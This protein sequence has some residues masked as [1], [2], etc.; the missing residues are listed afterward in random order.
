MSGLLYKA[1]TPC[2]PRSKTSRFDRSSNES[3]GFD[4]FWDDH[5]DSFED[6]ENIDFTTEIRAPV[7]T[8]VKPRR[9]NRTTTSFQI[10]DENEG[11][12]SSPG[13]K[14]KR[15]KVTTTA[16]SN[17]KSALLS[18]PAQ[19]FRPRANFAPNPQSKLVRQPM[20]PKNNGGSDS[21]IERNKVL[22]EQINGKSQGSRKT[23]ALKKDVRRNTVYI[24]DDTTVATAFMGL[25]S[26]LKSHALGGAEDCT[27]EDTQINSL[28]SRIATKRQ[29]RRPYRHSPKPAPLQPS[30]KPAQ[31]TSIRVDIA[32]KNGGKENIPPHGSFRKDGEPEKSLPAVNLPQ[33]PKRAPDN[34][35]GT[36]RPTKPQYKT[37]RTF[38]NRG[39]RASAAKRVGPSQKRA[40]LGDKQPNARPPTIGT[41][42]K[43][44]ASSKQKLTAEK[45]SV[46]SRNPKSLG[47][48]RCSGTLTSSNPVMPDLKLKR[49]NTEYPLLIE[50]ISNPAMYNDNWLLHQEIVITQ[51]VNGLFD[52]TD[53]NPT[54]DDPE[55]LRYELLKLYQNE[56]F[57]QFHKR[58]QASLEYGPMS[59]PNFVL[60]RGSSLKKDLGL[61]RKLIDIL[62]RTYDLHTL[63]AAIEIV[64]GRRIPDDPKP[65]KK[66]IGAAQNE[67]GAAK[68]KMLRQKLENFIEVFL[69]RNEDMD[70]S[71]RGHKS[72][73]ADAEARAYRRTVLRSIMIITLLD[74]A[75]LRPGMMLPRQLF[76][77]SSIFK[78]SAAVVQALGRLLLPS[79]GDI[80]KPLGHLDCRLS[81]KQHE[82]QEYEYQI[83][84]LAV[85]L[86]DGVRLTR[87]VELL[88]YP[89]TLCP[90]S[91]ECNLD[92]S[93]TVV[94]PNG[95]SAPLSGY[96][97]NFPL[98][99][100][101]RFPCV[102]RAVK[103]FN[104]RIALGALGATT[105]T[106]ALVSDVLAEDIVDGHR[107][108]TIALLWGLVSKWGLGGLVDWDDVT[109]EIGRL[110][111][112][113]ISHYG[114]E[115]VKDQGW[116]NGECVG[117]LLGEHAPLLKQWTAL[118]AGMKGLQ[119]ENL[120][121]NFADGKIY[122]SIVD[123]YEGYI[124][125][126]KGCTV[127]SSGEKAD[128]QE[129]LK[130]R[131]QALGCSSQFC[132]CHSIASRRTPLIQIACLVSP[133]TYE[134]CHLL[135]SDFTLISLAFLC[136]RLLSAS[137]RARAAVTLQRAWRRIL[138]LREL[139]KRIIARDIARQCAAVV[140]ARDQII[141]AQD[142][143]ATWW[144]K[145][146]IRRQ[147]RQQRERRTVDDSIKGG[148]QWGRMIDLG[149][150]H[151]SA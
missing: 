143:I 97:G 84:N 32:G 18:Q 71:V 150:R 54:S 22:L 136:S 37:D 51:L 123:E 116:F 42:R 102:S 92:C 11:K 76:S 9:G 109:K 23:D 142:T 89:S 94:L 27:S 4:S 13:V 103:L 30:L 138:T 141:W 96:D 106:C 78:S 41:D 151:D 35:L 58:L 137:K 100:H 114:Y 55:A 79:S 115:E 67:L 132:M 43:E 65:S 60:A 113:A 139:P 40:V 83:D 21:N 80:T 99:Q 6:T 63:R 90:N 17:R 24:P 12:T 86:R 62:I 87:I 64:I 77:S 85:D 147:R 20:V 124:L 126:N 68:D 133:D 46:V 72:Q 145:V 10:H 49:L 19:R 14:Q 7:L 134:K 29:A 16:P 104:V 128:K 91:G 74:K 88:L 129:S 47:T 57:V 73:R 122:E 36:S 144:K 39:S 135:G 120:S 107:E 50:N 119:V 98:S 112:K 5:F 82:L 38:A 148:D 118:L 140:Q 110:K 53:G 131:L 3:N 111:R 33:K 69:L 127:S 125:K 108:K 130:S 45:E 75:R 28:E 61:K 101:L 1:E 117:E 59:M 121:T 34:I 52:Y 56:F 81:Y 66:S 70:Q 149:I 2:P 95:H 8:R 93:T 146:L 105:D 15:D 48:A 26:P 31:E 44:E 25:F